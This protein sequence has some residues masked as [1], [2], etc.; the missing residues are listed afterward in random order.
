MLAI[1]NFGTKSLNELREKLV[2]KGFLEPDDA[3]E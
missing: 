3:E 1:R 2:A